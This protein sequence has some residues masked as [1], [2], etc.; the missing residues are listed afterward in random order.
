MF[1]NIS[2]R[3]A[4]CAGSQERGQPLFDRIFCCCRCH[5]S[6][7]T[8]PNFTECGQLCHIRTNIEGDKFLA[9]FEIVF[10]EFNNDYKDSISCL[11]WLR[12]LC[13]Y[14]EGKVAECEVGS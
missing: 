3:I 13:S 4:Q 7:S 12:T 8:W 1:A 5:F 9:I 11:K 2:K 6:A 14:S 10:E